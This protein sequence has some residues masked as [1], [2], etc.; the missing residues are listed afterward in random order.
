MKNTTR[1]VKRAMTFLARNDQ[2]LSQLIARVGPCTLGPADDH[3]GKL[4]SS[5][6]AQ[7]LSVKA[8]S[9]I[10]SRFTTLVGN[11]VV[12]HR[13]LQLADDEFRSIGVSGQKTSFIKGLASHF[14]ENSGAWNELPSLETSQAKK[15]LCSVRGI[16]DWTAD[17]FL[18]FTLFRLDIL[19]VGDV[20]LQN[21]IK[22]F[23][24]LPAKP[25]A[26]EMAA[27]AANWGEYSSVASWYLWRAYD[28]LNA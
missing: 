26:R 21:A 1:A 28:A 5:I 19:P 15:F 25:D 6:I 27:I 24:E 16:G 17:M 12:P 8:A 9:T 2:V 23:Y 18:I 7:Q 22:K 20:G 13:I 11:E 3:F 10:K 4:C 14:I